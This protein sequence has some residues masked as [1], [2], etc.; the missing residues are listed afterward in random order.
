MQRYVGYGLITI[1]FIIFQTTVVPFAAILNI[2]PDVLLVWIV[3]VAIRL[4]QIPATVA[5]FA[6]GLIIDLVS[7]HFIGLSA[8][9][10]TVA[11]FVAGYFYNENKVD[12]TLGS[13]QFLIVVG[14]SSLVHNIIY[15]V[16]FVQ[17]S[18][19]TFWTAIFRFGLFST[20]Y[21]LVLA[22]LPVF[23]YSRKLA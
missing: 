2:V 8:L 21:T 12:Y 17:G 23:G 19:I 14:L 22:V 18:D 11:G 16:I 4:G 5:G 15:F 13:Y 9:S 20:I 6:I 1:G 3:Y 7:G 10:K